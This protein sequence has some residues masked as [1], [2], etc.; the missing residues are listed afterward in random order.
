M[1]QRNTG[2][3]PP[4]PFGESRHLFVCVADIPPLVVLRLKRPSCA[5]S[6]LL[7][8]VFPLSVFA[9]SVFPS[10][11]FPLF[12][13]FRSP[14]QSGITRGSTT[15]SMGGGRAGRRQTGQGH[16]LVVRWFPPPL[17]PVRSRSFHR[18]FRACLCVV[19]RSHI[20]RPATGPLRFSPGSMRTL[21]FC[22][23]PRI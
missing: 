9:L 23:A 10:F 3:Y 12:V 19:P 5:V 18:S 15:L 20:E 6:V 17:V 21:D 22:Y 7:S 11:V 1:P 4:S 13:R 2:A 16:V 14:S 8:F